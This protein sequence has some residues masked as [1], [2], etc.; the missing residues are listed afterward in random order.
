MCVEVGNIC[1]DLG[2]E[3]LDDS[4]MELTAG[5]GT[6]LIAGGG[7]ELHTKDYFIHRGGTIETKHLLPASH[8]LCAQKADPNS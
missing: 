2:H 5:G 6:E 1:N 7:T 4:W 3:P 8:M